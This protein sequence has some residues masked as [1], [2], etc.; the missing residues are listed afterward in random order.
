MSMIKGKISNDNHQFWCWDSKVAKQHQAPGG[1]LPRTTTKS[2]ERRAFHVINF[3]FASPFC[4]EMFTAPRASI[5]I[6]AL[7]VERLREKGWRRLGKFLINSRINLLIMASLLLASFPK[8]LPKIR[9]TPTVASSAICSRSAWWCAR[10]STMES[11]WFRLKI[12]RR[13]ISNNSNRWVSGGEQLRLWLSFRYH[14]S[15]LGH[16]RHKS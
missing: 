3:P 14:G 6:T 7:N 4:R 13:R 12:H 9:W 8:Q 5:D 11:H 10:Y 2:T 16:F 15:K 1:F